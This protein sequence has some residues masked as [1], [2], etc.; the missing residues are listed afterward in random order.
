MSYP[1]HVHMFSKT[2][3]GEVSGQTRKKMLP[4]TIPG[5]ASRDSAESLQGVG[6]L[7]VHE[8]EH[9]SESPNFDRSLVPAMPRPACPGASA[10]SGTSKSTRHVHLSADALE[11]ATVL[12]WTIS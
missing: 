8:V 4:R 11:K 10:L 3:R 12:R 6:P 1:I 7:E 5:W 2:K 9:I